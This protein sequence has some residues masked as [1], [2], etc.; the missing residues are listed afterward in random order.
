MN[1]I[2]KILWVVLL[3]LTM[4][5]KQYGQTVKNNSIEIELSGIN[6]PDFRYCLLS[7]ISNDDN[8]IYTVDEDNNSVLLT[9]SSS[10]DNTEFQAYYDE[11]YVQ[12]QTE[13]NTFLDSDKEAQGSYYTAW[14]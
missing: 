14:K 12:A 3:L 8:I 10:M 2:A 9:P 6:N 1:N 11:L 4:P 13:F 7:S 5:M